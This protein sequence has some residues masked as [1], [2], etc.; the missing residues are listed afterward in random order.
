MGERLSRALHTITGGDEDALSGSEGA[1][2]PA[3]QILPE[4]GVDCR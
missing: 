4:K 3:G 1:A 2:K